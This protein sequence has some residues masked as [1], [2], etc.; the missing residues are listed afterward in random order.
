MFVPA[1]N[2]S[3]SQVVVDDEGRTLGGGEWGAVDRHDEIAQVAIGDSRI[4]IFPDLT[5]AP[6]LDPAARDA[7]AETAVLEARRIKLANLDGDQL[8]ALA[9]AAGAEVEL[10]NLD[11]PADVDRIRRW[12]TRRVEISLTSTPAAEPALAPPDNPSA[13]GPS[14]APALPKPKRGGTAR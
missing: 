3:D 5:D 9:T 2:V 1:Q 6:D 7:L 14:D 4:A 12:L 8:A 11:S 13:S 10:D